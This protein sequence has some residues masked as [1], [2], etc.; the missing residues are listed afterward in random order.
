MDSCPACGGSG[1]GP[2]GPPGSLWDREEYRCKRCGGTG[3][4]GVEEPSS[5]PG[6][7]KSADAPIPSTQRTG[8]EKK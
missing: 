2:F 3:V 8:T 7:L 6:V 1:G 4:I 5:G